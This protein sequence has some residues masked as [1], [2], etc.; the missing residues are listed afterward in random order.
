MRKISVMRA[1]ETFR[2]EVPIKLNK[3]SGAVTKFDVT[4]AG[5]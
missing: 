3:E 4:V 5:C 1:N 2:E